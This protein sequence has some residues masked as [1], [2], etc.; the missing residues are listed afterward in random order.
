LGGGE[1]QADGDPDGFVDIVGLPLVIGLHHFEYNDEPRRDFE[2]G[3][4]LVR[5]ERLEILAPL[6]ADAPAIE[7]ALFFLGGGPDF[8]LDR[9]AA[10]RDKAPGLFVGARWRGPCGSDNV[11]DGLQRNRAVGVLRWRTMS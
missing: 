9:G 6:I 10:D 8:G 5:A 4:V 11:L 1:Q 2:E 3:F 7:L